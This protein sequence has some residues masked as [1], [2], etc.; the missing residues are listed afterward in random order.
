MRRNK[1]LNNKYIYIYFYYCLLCFRL[2]HD[3]QAV[4]SDVHTAAD[5]GV[6]EGV[7]LQPLPDQAAPHRNRPL[8]V[9]ERAANQN[10]VPKPPH[11]GQKGWQTGAAVAAAASASVGGADGCGAD[12]PPSAASFARP[13]SLLQLLLRGNFLAFHTGR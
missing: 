6:G 7:P 8:A 2:G 12:A 13:G 11:E 3:G 10:L 1:Y 5:A 4:A 9:T